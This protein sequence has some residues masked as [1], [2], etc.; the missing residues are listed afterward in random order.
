M[1]K[2]AARIWNEIEQVKVERVAD[3][4]EEDA[5]A[6]GAKKAIQW[7][8]T[9]EIEYLEEGHLAYDSALYRLG[10]K[11]LWNSINGKPKPQQSI[12]NGKLITTGYT[13]Y[14]F[15]E[16]SAKSFAGKTKWRGKPLTVIINPW[17]WVVKFKVLSKTGKPSPN[18]AKDD[19]KPQICYKTGE[20]CKYDCK[21][22]CR[23]SM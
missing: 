3:I 20:I 8:H 9:G 11:K 6:E 7:M 22:L 15:D 14:P 23:E 12:E 16:E 4:S 1:P 5:K 10:F 13:V 21:G 19:S 2:P 18:S 17:V